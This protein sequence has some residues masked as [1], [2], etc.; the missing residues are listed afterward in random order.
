MNGQVILGIPTDAHC[1]SPISW[2]KVLACEEVAR[3]KV[4]GG[5]FSGYLVY[6]VYVQHM[7][8]NWQVMN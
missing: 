4:L 3:D 2:V 8:Y 6:L 7:T 5:G 1:L